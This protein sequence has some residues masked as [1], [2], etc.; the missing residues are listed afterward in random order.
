ME[1]P[2]ITV[3]GPGGVG[4][5]TLTLRL[6]EHL[7]WHLL[8]SGAIYR[9]LALYAEAKGVDLEDEAG[10]EPL[11]LAL[12]LTFQQ[13]EGGALKI[14]L[15]GVD[16]T[17]AIRAEETGGKAS[18]VA[19]FPKVREALLERQRDFAQAPGLIADGRDMGSEIF[20]KALLKIFLT[21]SSEERAK[22]RYKQLLDAGV[23]ANIER[24]LSEIE[25]RDERDRTRA[26]SPLIPA[27]D[28]IEIDTSFM[29][30][31]EVFKTVLEAYK[32]KIK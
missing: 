9:A 5:G 26:A 25:A 10:L 30:V 24:V 4:K 12:P 32:A 3:D 27:T 8:D 13:G 1:I 31:D 23:C 21:A 14:I 17:Q 18:K 7:G 6:A 2:V 15:D 28:A 20:P 16:S 22:R 29:S 11:A 19:K